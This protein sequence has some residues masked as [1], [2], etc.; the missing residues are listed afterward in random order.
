MTKKEQ[1]KVKAFDKIREI[2][3]TIQYAEALKQQLA[4]LEMQIAE[5]D[6]KPEDE[7]ETTDETNS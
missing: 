7:E 2:H 1:L 5:L 6:G 3:N 4:D